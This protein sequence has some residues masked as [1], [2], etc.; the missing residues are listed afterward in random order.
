MIAAY[1]SVKPVVVLVSPSDGL[2]IFE[3]PLRH[4]L[5]L[6]QHELLFFRETGRDLA[7]SGDRVVQFEIPQDFNVSFQTRSF[8]GLVTGMGALFGI[9][10]LDGLPDGVEVGPMLSELGRVLE[11]WVLHAQLSV[12]KKAKWDDHRSQELAMLYE[13]SYALGHS[14]NYYRVMTL[15]MDAIVNVI[16]VDVIGVLLLG[17]TKAG[18]GELIARLSRPVAA[19]LVK[20]VQHNILKTMVPFLGRDI[21]TSQISFVT[22]TQYDV[23]DTRNPISQMKSFVNVPLIFKDTVLGIV[24]ISTHKLN[25]YQQNEMTFLHTMVNQMASHLGRLKLVKDSEQTKIGSMIGSMAEGI[26]MLDEL[27]HLD[28]INSSARELLD[29]PGDVSA[30]DLMDRLVRLGVM[31]LFYESVLYRKAF[32]DQTLTF[33]PVILSANISPVFGSDN[34]N[35]GT[36]MVFRDVTKS[37]QMER[38]MSQRLAIIGEVAKVLNSISDLEKLLGILMEFILSFSHAQM[39]AIQL[40]M[41]DGF[42]TK[43]HSNFPD[44]IRRQYR[45]LNGETISRSVIKSQDSAVILD[46]DTHSLV[47]RQA[48]IAINAYV[49]IPI[50]VK[51]E[52]IGLINVVQKKSEDAQPL[53]PEDIDTLQM[54][55]SLSGAAIHNAALIQETLQA[56]KTD[57]ELRVAYDIQRRLLPETLPT[58]DVVSFGAMSRPARAIGG[59]YYDV[60]ELPDGTVGVIVADIVGKGVPAALF[61]VMFKTLV[62]TTIQQGVSQPA[63]LFNRLNELIDQERMFSRFVPAFY[64]VVDPDT[65]QLSYCNAGHEPAVWLHEGHFHDLSSE[66]L[67]LGADA[68]TVYDGAT[69]QLAPED[70]VSIFTDGIIEARD[71]DSAVFGYR[72]LKRLIREHATAGAAR[73]VDAIGH[74]VDT[75][76]RGCEQHDDM[77]IVVIADSVRTVT[78]VPLKSTTVRVKSRKSEIVVVRRVV[79]EIATRMRF[80]ESVVFDLKLALNEAQANIIEHVYLGREDGEICVDFHEF[81]DRL[82]IFITDYGSGITK[83][84]TK[85]S[86]DLGQ[87]EGSGLGVFLIHELMDE[88]EMV[89]QSHLGSVLKLVKR[90]N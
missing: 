48:K 71:A 61:M 27:H 34:V 84:S 47:N 25:A 73:L 87:L 63:D 20:R 8:F 74:R 29:L 69:I 17:F 65:R 19:D 41:S 5:I 83:R 60:F 37:I 4:G 14:L 18:D 1:A 22:Q 7:A 44:K 68:Q 12:L 80:S 79:D 9:V 54:I 46:Y 66:N 24:N 62:Q 21:D 64:G 53:M 59:D 11:P 77:T 56:Q 88:V 81:S 51:N 86:A 82:E 26:I 31:D 40:K 67:P 52:L 6:G 90:L 89:R 76:M 38:L 35:L 2:P 36:V 23:S 55:A 33:G 70:V 45:Y 85:G 78:D 15:V 39:G 3:Y 58:G 42:V 13:T 28:V 10:W 49:C 32:L 75:F 16:D 30:E 50:K 57:Q 72:R 43:V